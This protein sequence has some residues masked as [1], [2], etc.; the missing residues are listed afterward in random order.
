[1]LANA[2]RICEAKFG[3]LCSARGRCVPR[4]RACTTR[5]PP[6][7]RHA[8][9]AA[10][11]AAAT[12]PSGALAPR[13]R[14]SRSTTSR[15]R[16]TTRLASL[17][18]NSAGSRTVVCVPMLKDDE[19]IGAIGIYRQE[20]RHSPTSRSIWCTNFAAQAVIAIENTRLLNELRE[21]LQQQT[22]TAEVL[23]GHQPFDR[24]SADRAETML[25]NAAR[26]CEAE[27]RR[28]CRPR[29]MAIRRGCD[30]RLAAGI[31]RTRRRDPM[32]PA[33]AVGTSAHGDQA[34]AQS[35]IA[36]VLAEPDYS[37]RSG[38]P[39]SGGL[40]DARTVLGVPMLKED[41][42]IGVLSSVANRC[43]RSPTSRSSWST[44]FADQAVIAIE[45]MRLFDEL[46]ARV[47]RAGAADRDLGSAQGHLQLARRT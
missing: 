13:S 19:L 47:P 46:R 12:P 21:S 11:P 17:R 39:S 30:A 45:N 28:S 5:R 31:G 41:E 34:S 24:R 22:A 7:P 25:A 4:R 40:A 44:K 33:A 1:M 6:M 38:S 23:Q 3:T 42:P 8:A 15:R 43:G 36:D 14:S 26:L 18:L 37:N 27:V 9:R 29:A 10:S 2:T 16:L 32:H 20:V 35:H